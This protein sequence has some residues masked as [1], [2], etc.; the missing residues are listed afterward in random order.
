MNTDVGKY[1]F[2]HTMLRVRDLDKSIDFYTRHLGMEVLR[3]R[4]F[5][6]GKFTLVFLGY[7]D[8]EDNTVIE[9]T[10]NWGQTEAYEH[11]SAFGHLAIAVPDIYKTCAELETAGVPIPRRPGPMKFG[12]SP[13]VMA[14][15]DDPDGYKIELIQRD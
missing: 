5:P 4:D 6:D 12:G 1:R 2:L 7:G 13:V 9:L 14:F 11:G 8:E 3:N 15:I 10:H